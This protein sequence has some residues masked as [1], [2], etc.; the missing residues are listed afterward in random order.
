M[1]ILIYYTNSHNYCFGMSKVIRGMGKAAGPVGKAGIA[2]GKGIGAGGALVTILEASGHLLG[3]VA[4]LFDKLAGIS[5]V[6]GAAILVRTKKLTKTLKLAAKLVAVFGGFWCAW[7]WFG[8]PLGPYDVT[9]QDAPSS[10]VLDGYWPFRTER[11]IAARSHIDR[12]QAL[13]FWGMWLSACAGWV[14]IGLF[15]AIVRLEKENEQ[16]TPTE[17][18]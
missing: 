9:I 15:D 11:V 1:I 13:S 4:G 3:L 2:G 10:V 5:A 17:P 12:R 6:I 18:S 7:K 8:W 14:A 16:P